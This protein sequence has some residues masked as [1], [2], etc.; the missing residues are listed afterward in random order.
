MSRRPEVVSLLAGVL[1]SCLGGAVAAAPVP[2]IQLTTQVLNATCDLSSQYSPTLGSLYVTPRYGWVQ[3]EP[4]RAESTEKITSGDSFW[5]SAYM[6]HSATGQGD[7]GCGEEMASF[8][9]ELK[10][11]ICSVSLPDRIVG[12]VLVVEILS[13]HERWNKKTECADPHY[14]SD[15]KDL[16][17]QFTTPEGTSRYADTLFGS[18]YSVTGWEGSFLFPDSAGYL[19]G[20]AWETATPERSVRNQRAILLLNSGAQSEGG[21]LGAFTL[22]LGFNACEST[23]RVTLR[24]P[25]LETPPAP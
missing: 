16:P 17:L 19:C 5:L 12:S 21:F 7:T 25:R 14:F 9:V 1:L 4:L 2:S 22:R 8:D 6:F 11:S 23:Y 15:G 18:W 10:V 20:G 24:L 13:A 3:S